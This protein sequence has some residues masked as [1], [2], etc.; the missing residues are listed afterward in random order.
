METKKPITHIVAGLIIAA[1][2]II[3]SLVLQFAG[4]QQDGALGW[5]AWGIL[6]ISIIVFVNMYGNANNNY[7]SF[8][9]LFAYGFK[10]TAI[11]MLVV[12]A[13]TL[14]MFTIMP[15]IKEKV[16]E[17]ARRGMEEQGKMSDTD[18]DKAIELTRKFFYVF[19][20]G[21]ILL[22]YAILGAIGSLIGAAITKKR[23]HNPLEQLD[24]R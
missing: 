6:I 2:Q 11:A 13:F 5:L 17:E 1:F 19:M 21:G 24:M 3:Y 22:M 20:I 9:N 23:P 10:A 14:L 15:E 16:F 8:G 12:I 7:P 4:M 18:I